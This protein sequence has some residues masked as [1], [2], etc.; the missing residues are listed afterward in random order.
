VRDRPHA[1]GFLP[2]LPLLII[3]L[4]GCSAL[5]DDDGAT[6]TEREL[7]GVVLQP[8]DLP[9]V[10]VRFDEGR[11]IGPD[12]PHGARADTSRFGRV[13]GW[14]ARYR[15][16][17]SRSTPGALLI[18]SRADLF[19]DEEGAERDFD[20]VEEDPGEGVVAKRVAV[21]S[22]GDEAVG[23]SF[24]QGAGEAEVRYVVTSWRHG[25][26]VASL[27]ASGF[28]DSFTPDEGLELARKQARRL[29]RAVES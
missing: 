3:V 23:V 17:G 20:L 19:G 22:L 28:A 6:V 7:P 11:Q 26:V 12:A 2:V 14:K 9:Q 13:E 18:E 1:R 8:A 27:R 25:N 16:P 24:V 21:G 29:A 10:W 5:A 15:R 4:G